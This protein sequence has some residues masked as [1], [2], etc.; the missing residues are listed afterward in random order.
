MNK[1]NKY[2]VNIGNV[3]Q[4]TSVIVKYESTIP[5]AI[6]HVSPGCTECTKFMDYKD[7][8]LTVKYFAPELSRHLMG[9]PQVI[10]KGL[11]VYYEDGTKDELKFVGFLTR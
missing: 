8:I 2:T 4:K 3:K 1:W 6:Q 7:N 10:N 11:T 9:K 5:L